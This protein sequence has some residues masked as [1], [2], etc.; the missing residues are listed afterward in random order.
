M[1]SLPVSM[2][3]QKSCVK[4]RKDEQRVESEVCSNATVQDGLLATELKSWK[5]RA[6]SFS[7]SYV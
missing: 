5:H 4:E 3:L 2:F 7:A 6:E 1:D